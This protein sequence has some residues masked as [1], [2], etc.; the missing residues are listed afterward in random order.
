MSLKLITG[1]SV[2]PISLSETKLH[3]HVDLNDDDLWITSAI[4]ACR[5]YAEKFMGRALVTQTWEL[6]LDGF[7]TAEIEIPLPPLLSV[8][9]VKYDDGN[10]IEQTMDPSLY[11]VDSASQPARLSFV[12]SWPN[13][14]SNKLGSVR[15]RF[16]AG[17]PT[18]LDSPDNLIANI[19]Q[20]IKN[21]IL[22]HVGMLYANRENVIV[23]TNVMVLPWA[24]A[25][26][27]FRQYRVE[28]SMA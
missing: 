21:A 27:L 12:S 23:G 26:V 17:Y 20:S 18:P 4:V 5:I 9:S 16:I 28:V 3:L 24:G 6:G 25:D 22:L 15:V 8:V 11:R 10:G 2:E 1:P 13:T 19:P 7:P 14:Q